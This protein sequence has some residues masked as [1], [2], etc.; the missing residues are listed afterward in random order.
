MTWPKVIS[1][2][3]GHSSH[4]AKFLVLAI[5]YCHWIWIFHTIV[6]HD[7]RVCLDLDLRSNLLCLGHAIHSYSL[8]RSKLTTVVLEL[9]NISHKLSMAQGCHDLDPVPYF[10]GQCHTAHIAIIVVCATA[11]DHYCCFG[12]GYFA[13]LSSMTKEC[14]TTLTAN[15]FFRSRSHCT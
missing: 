13:Q 11:H 10:Q 5:S 15:Y 1:P 2:G 6:V 12:F 4:L 8:P 3:Q 9:N 14:V 7:L